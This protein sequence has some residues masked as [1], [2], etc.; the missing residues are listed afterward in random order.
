MGWGVCQQKSWWRRLWWV[1]WFG[2]VVR[3]RAWDQGGHPALRVLQVFVS[4]R[5]VG[6]VRQTRAWIAVIVSRIGYISDP[7]LYLRR[8]VM[9]LL[10]CASWA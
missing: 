7:A 8:R 10:H 2:D 4:V 9:I 5:G 1:I 3:G 6:A